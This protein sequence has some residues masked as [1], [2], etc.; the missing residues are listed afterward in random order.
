MAAALGY[1][2]MRRR[3]FVLALRQALRRWGL[4]A[5]VAAAAAGAGSND[6][7]GAALSLPVMLA[8]PL[9]RAL[10]HG[11]LLQGLAWVG[12]SAWLGLLPLLLTR[13][14]WW[15]VRWAEAERALPLDPAQLRRS[16]RQVALWLLLPWHGL[17]ALGLL[18]P[19]LAGGARPS[20]FAAWALALAGSL[21]IGLAWMARLRRGP[22]IA[23][24]APA[25]TRPA[26]SRPRPRWHTWW[27]LPLRRGAARGTA[28]LLLV[29]GLAEPALAAGTA[30]APQAS[31]WWLAAL[32]LA[33]LA[34]TSLL[35]LRIA[36]DW[37]GWRQAAAAWPWAP[38]QID[39]QARWLALAPVAAGT[40]S[41]LLALAAGPT[42]PRGAVA[43]AYGLAL[44]LACWLEAH[45]PSADATHQAARWLLMAAFL[46]ALGTEV[47]P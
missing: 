46:V 23:A 3:A 34:G 11:D 36:A 14:W 33:A 2:A 27:W 29:F 24:A 19:A 28:R 40:L 16:D 20:A 43:A 32:A 7:V 9:H 4:F 6:P 30:A 25:S 47:M 26:A 10:A 38:S 31:G 44:P 22:A 35:R 42:A 5:L 45:P 37:A 17:T 12:A 21:L 13:R 41:L 8:W 1:Q 39:R 15:P 18:L